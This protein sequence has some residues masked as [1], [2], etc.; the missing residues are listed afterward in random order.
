M[1]QT[2]RVF[3]HE[4]LAMVIAYYSNSFPYL[5]LFN[6]PR[7]LLKLGRYVDETHLYILP[8]KSSHIIVFLL[9]FFVHCGKIFFF[10]N[11]AKQKV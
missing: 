9:L 5:K 3:I 1:Q 6:I 8:K 10:Q 11:P 7:K 4:T 2:F